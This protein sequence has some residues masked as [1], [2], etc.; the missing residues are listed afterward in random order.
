MPENRRKWWMIIGGVA[1]VGFLVI[2][3][4][5]FQKNLTPYVSFDEARKAGARVQI[6]GELVPES[7]S[8]DGE[9]GELMFAIRDP[10]GGE[11]AIRYM[12]VKP[13]NFEEATQIVAIGTWSG[14]FFGAERL[15]VKCPSKY[16]GVDDDPSTHS[17]TT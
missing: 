6:A 12:D 17:A 16:Q 8:Y 1:I 10:E 5:S 9:S 11:M 14:E 7:P 2:G 13:A 3:A 15:L 4:T